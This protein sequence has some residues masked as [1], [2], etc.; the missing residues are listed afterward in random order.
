MLVVLFFTEDK[1][2]KGRQILRTNKNEEENKKE[3]W[4]KGTVRPD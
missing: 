3:P 4:F 1:D 2:N